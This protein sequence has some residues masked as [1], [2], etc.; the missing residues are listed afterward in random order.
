[1]NQNLFCN[2]KL[3]LPMCRTK[4]L[5]SVSYSKQVP[6]SFVVDDGVDKIV[7]AYCS[8]A[9]MMRKRIISEKSCGEHVRGKIIVS[10]FCTLG[11]HG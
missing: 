3:I 6:E 9:E 8:I 1:M 11:N 5:S 10:R 4:S 2:E 7:F